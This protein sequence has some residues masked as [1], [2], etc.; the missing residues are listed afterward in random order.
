MLLPGSKALKVKKNTRLGD[1][2]TANA[3]MFRQTVFRGAGCGRRIAAV[4]HVHGGGEDSMFLSDLLKRI[5]RINSTTKRLAQDRSTKRPAGGPQGGSGQAKNREATGARKQASE[6]AKEPVKRESVKVA[7]HPLFGGRLAARVQRSGAEGQGDNGARQRGQGQQ[8]ARGARRAPRAPRDDAQKELGKRDQSRRDGVNT[9]AKRGRSGQTGKVSDFAGP[10]AAPGGVP[11]QKVASKQLTYGPF[12]P[13]LSASSL[14][15]GKVS[16]VSTSTSVRLASVA[17]EVLLESNYPYKLPRDVINTI[18]PGVV[19]NK[20]VL[21]SNYSL[22][23]DS[24]K[25]QT[26]INEV[27]RGRIPSA[28]ESDAAE[29]LPG[30][31]RAQKLIHENNT[32]SIADKAKVFGAAAGLLSP[33]QLVEGAHWI[34]S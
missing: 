8:R 19:R 5:D 31:E 27:V 9:G 14:F 28:P 6:G 25:L 34:K 2:D 12:L 29:K 32:M 23:V 1:D 33:S 30:V 11:V 10:R 7:D 13:Q 22:E 18:R 3:G 26:R 16:G 20:F 21:Q 17:K 24:D 4:R 15:Y